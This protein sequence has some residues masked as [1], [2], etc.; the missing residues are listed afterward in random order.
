[1]R[2]SPKDYLAMVDAV[3]FASVARLLGFEKDQKERHGGLLA[4]ATFNQMSPYDSDVGY[5]MIG[6][7]GGKL[8]GNMYFVSEKIRRL[9]RMRQGG[10]YHYAASQSACPQEEKYAGAVVGIALPYIEV[11]IGYSGAPAEIDEALCHLLAAKVFDLVLPDVNYYN[12]SL[13]RAA[14]LMGLSM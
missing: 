14:D 13:G 1:M 10:H 4:I 7:P 5:L 8:D 6:A 11:Y 3:L 9:R 2:T 12:P